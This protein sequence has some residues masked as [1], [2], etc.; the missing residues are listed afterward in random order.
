MLVIDNYVRYWIRHRRYSTRRISQEVAGTRYSRL[1]YILWRYFTFALL[2][3]YYWIVKST[4]FV[5]LD[6]PYI[7]LL[8]IFDNIITGEEESSDDELKEKYEADRFSA[9]PTEAQKTP[10]QQTPIDTDAEQR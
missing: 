9:T 10:G 6:H 8:I 3:C 4:K 7:Y 2:L 5:R 1:A